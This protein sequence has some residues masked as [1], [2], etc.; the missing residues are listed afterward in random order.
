MISNAKL[1][2]AMSLA[3]LSMSLHNPTPQK[4]QPKNYEKKFPRTNM[5][6]IKKK[7]EQNRYKKR[8]H[9]K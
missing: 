6:K 5:V 4:W 8:K 1:V 2:A 9:S 3:M 7:E